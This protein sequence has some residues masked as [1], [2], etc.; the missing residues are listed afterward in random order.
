CRASL[1]RWRRR[2]REAVPAH[3][4][5]GVSRNLE[6][7]LR[8]LD[9]ASL[10][11]KSPHTSGWVFG[12]KL[13]VKAGEER[14]R[15]RDGAAAIVRGSLGTVDKPGLTQPGVGIKLPADGDTLSGDGVFYVGPMPVKDPDTFFSSRGREAMRNFVGAPRGSFKLGIANFA[16]S[17]VDH[18]GHRT[19]QTWFQEDGR[20]GY[21]P[22][23]VVPEVRLRPTSRMSMNR[24]EK[25]P[26]VASQRYDTERLDRFRQ[27][28][29]PPPGYEVADV[30]LDE[31]KLSVGP[32]GKKRAVGDRVWLTIRDANGDL[33]PAQYRVTHAETREVVGL[34]G[35]KPKPPSELVLRARPVERTA[36]LRTAIRATMDVRLELQRRVRPGDIMYHMD[37]VMPDGRVRSDVATLEATSEAFISP[38]GDGELALHHLGPEDAVPQTRARRALQSLASMFAGVFGALGTKTCPMGH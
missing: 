23:A 14:G 6:V 7:F 37:L 3:L 26:S 17:L 29:Q 12:G 10:R 19:L 34:G 38:A 8:R 27:S 24:L 4:L 2:R 9:A 18:P 16:F 28:I 5:F 33:L 22:D 36:E 31:I 21:D 30:A 35:D 1:A 15:L 11:A 25:C 20:G 13:N 32:D